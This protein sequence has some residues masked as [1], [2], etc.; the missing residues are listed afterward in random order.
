[1]KKVIIL[2]LTVIITLSAFSIFASAQNEI[3]ELSVIS[4]NVA[5]L[6]A[7]LSKYDRDVPNAQKTLGKMLNESG[8]DI[9]CV[10]EDFGYH[11]TLAA[12][13]TNYPYATYTSGGVPI[14]DGLNIFSKYPIY[15]VERVA[16]K[17]FNGFFTDGMDALTPKGFMKCTVD[18]CG[19]FIDLYNVHNDAYRTDADQRAKKSQLVQ[20]TGYIE[21]N[22]KGRPIIVTGDTN[23]T[24]HTD[25][26]AE[27]YRIL[28]DE[29]GFTDVW[30][31]MKNDENYMQG[32]DGQQLIDDWYEKFGGHDWGRWDSVER[33]LYKNGDGLKFKP[34][35][36]EYVVYSDDANDKKA[37]TD[38]RMMECIIEIDISEYEKPTGIVLMQEKEPSFLY[39]IFHG[40]A[41]LLRFL[42]WFSVGACLYFVPITYDSVFM[43][44]LLI[45]S[46]FCI[47]YGT[48]RL[49]GQNTAKAYI[50]RRGMRWLI[51]GLPLLIFYLILLVFFV[52]TS[53]KVWAILLVLLILIISSAIT[54]HLTSSKKG[55]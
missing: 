31:E 44:V 14:G 33:L 19:V 50:R 20:L 34:L 37:L 11:S 38:H 22:A 35:R 16:W 23:L 40:A 18:V 12:Q 54:N 51:F 32:E 3:A 41:M 42:Y 30:I 27:M 49:L 2:F 1:M 21:E 8:Y 4:A 26:L 45:L 29:N 47:I 13:M 53:I 10:Q 46:I 28:I 43:I 39:S 36:F 52:N 6:P 5:G 55:R 15:N 7:F 9:I 24:F 17:E 25:P 48:A